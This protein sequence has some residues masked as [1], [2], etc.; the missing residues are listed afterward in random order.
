MKNKTNQIKMYNECNGY[1]TTTK[2]L[3][4]VYIGRKL[5]HQTEF[6]TIYRYFHNKKTAGSKIRRTG[7]KSLEN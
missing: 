7:L 5:I 6:Y 2:Q 4:A 3:P 1:H